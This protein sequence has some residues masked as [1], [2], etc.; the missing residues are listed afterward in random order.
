MQWPKRIAPP[1]EGKGTRKY[2][3]SGIPEV[4][5]NL[6]SKIEVGRA[7]VAASRGDDA[8]R[9]RGNRL[10]DLHSRR[11]KYRGRDL[12]R[13]TDYA[14]AICSIVAAKLARFA[15]SATPANLTEY[16]RRSARGGTFSRNLQIHS[17]ENSKE[18]IVSLPRIRGSTCTKFR[19]SR[20]RGIL[21]AIFL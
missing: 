16:P 7:V 8:P 18:E 14:P 12:S 15:T 20:G 4:P 1:G 3:V 10:A 5:E 19:N 11:D 2:R 13:C 9:R 6:Q 21:I 17:L